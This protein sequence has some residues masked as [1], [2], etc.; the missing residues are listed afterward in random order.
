MYEG[1][2]TAYRAHRDNVSG[3]DNS[4]ECICNQHSKPSINLPLCLG[5]FMTRFFA[6][7]GSF[8]KDEGGWLADREQAD[9][10][11][12]A[13]IYLNHVVR[14]WRSTVLPTVFCSLFCL[15]SALC[16]CPR[17]AHCFRSRF[18][19]GCLERRNGGR[20]TAGRCDVI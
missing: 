6:G 2:G 15:R 3:G 8:M 10:E 14:L 7:V 16:F 5:S 1:S 11:I 19:S 9:R 13:I 20:N 18:T 17:S 4:I 12:T